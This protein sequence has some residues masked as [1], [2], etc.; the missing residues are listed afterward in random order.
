MEPGGVRFSGLGECPR[1]SAGGMLEFFCAEEDA[2][3]R[4][5]AGVVADLA[6]GDAEALEN[7]SGGRGLEAGDM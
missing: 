2:V 1:G 3:G 6:P 4:H 5:R 7:E